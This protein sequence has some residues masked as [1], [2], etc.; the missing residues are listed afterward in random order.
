MVWNLIRWL[1]QKQADIDLPCFQKRINQGTAG[2]GFT[3]LDQNVRFWY[4]SQIHKTGPHSAVGIM[5]NC[6]SRGR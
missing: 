3:K 6:G 4:L 5:S 2:Q 1:R